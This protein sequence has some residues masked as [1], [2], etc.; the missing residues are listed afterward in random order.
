M[1]D[2]TP[3]AVLPGYEELDNGSADIRG[4]VRHGKHEFLYVGPGFFAGH[5]NT[6]VTRVQAVDS[7]SRLLLCS[8]EGVDGRLCFGV[9]KQQVVEVIDL[10]AMSAIPEKRGRIR[11]YIERQGAI[12]P[13]VDIA[14][15]L[16]LK[17]VAIRTSARL[18]VASGTKTSQL[19]ALL[20]DDSIRR[21]SP[22]GWSVSRLE[23]GL[24]TQFLRGVFSNRQETMVVP[25]LDL[26]P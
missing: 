26:L 24:N 17:P 11:G 1:I 7:Q 15:C 9:N 20:A 8:M 23:D 14:A 25:D 16:G 6:P 4:M 10:V 21:I 2:T 13:V 19:K 5:D 22:R 12:V 18:V 3:V